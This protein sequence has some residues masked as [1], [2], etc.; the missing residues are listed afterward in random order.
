MAAADSEGSP[1]W[2]L[3]LSLTVVA[4]QW[5]GQSGSPDTSKQLRSNLTHSEFAIMWAVHAQGRAEIDSWVGWKK[6]LTMTMICRPSKGPSTQTDVQYIWGIK[7]AWEG[8][9][10][11]EKLPNE[12]FW[13]DDS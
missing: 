7:I 10:R 2:V 6:P 12:A 13:E 4:G 8:G 5:K 9:S 3:E 11:G 1:F